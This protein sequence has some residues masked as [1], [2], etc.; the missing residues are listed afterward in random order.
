M[1]VMLNHRLGD[2]TCVS[3]ACL[4]PV[5]RIRAATAE[6][7]ADIALWLHASGETAFEIVAFADGGNRHAPEV[8]AA[9]LDLFAQPGAP[10]QLVYAHRGHKV[11]SMM[12]LLPSLLYGLGYS[13]SCC[14]IRL[15]DLASD[16]EATIYAKRFAAGQIPDDGTAG[17]VIDRQ[18]RLAPPGRLAPATVDIMLLDRVALI[19]WGAPAPA[20]D[21]VAVAKGPSP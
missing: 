1:D 18:D 10:G 7:I 13:G 5:V 12:P 8:I 21:H 2:I 20:I 4:R 3:V 17:L 9:L 15:P 11:E 6:E 19:V 16:A 14:A